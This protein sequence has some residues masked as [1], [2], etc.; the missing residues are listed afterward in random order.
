MDSTYQQR[1]LMFFLSNNDLTTTIKNLT[2]HLNIILS[3]MLFLI[4]AKAAIHSAFYID[5]V[6][7]IAMDTKRQ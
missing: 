7:I 1:L 4:L 3:V 5:D 2:S 6:I